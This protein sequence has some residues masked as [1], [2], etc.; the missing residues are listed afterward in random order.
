MCG[1]I[2]HGLLQGPGSII[3][4][5]VSK[6]IALPKIKWKKWKNEKQNKNI[7]K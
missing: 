1:Y 4:H 2:P 7:S 3:E 6:T 5:F